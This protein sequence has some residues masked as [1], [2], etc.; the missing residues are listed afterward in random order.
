MADSG[1]ILSQ[2]DAASAAKNPLRV[3][4]EI[5]KDKDLTGDDK[6]VLVEIWRRRFFHRRVMAYVALSAIVLSLVVLF[7][8]AF[9]VADFGSMLSEVSTLI[10]WIEGFLAGIVAAYYGMSALRPAS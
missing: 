4:A 6:R 8:G 5:L 10:T 2:V 1:N 3:L 7:L 9:L